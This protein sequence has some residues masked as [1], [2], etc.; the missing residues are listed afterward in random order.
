MTLIDDVKTV[1]DTNLGLAGRARDFTAATALFGSLPEI[2]SFAVVGLVAALEERFGITIDDADISL[3]SFETVGSLAQLVER[4]Q[5][6][7]KR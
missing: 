3:Q 5:A 7:A 1:L 6:S 4:L 2:D